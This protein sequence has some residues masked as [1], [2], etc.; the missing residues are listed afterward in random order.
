M[1]KA[2][3]FGPES[4]LSPS[5][6]RKVTCEVW[7]GLLLSPKTGQTDA[8]TMLGLPARVHG[9]P[10]G[11]SSSSAPCC[12]DSILGLPVAAHITPHN[13]HPYAQT[14]LWPDFPVCGHGTAPTAPHCASSCQSHA[15][16]LHWNFEAFSKKLRK[17]LLCRHDGHRPSVSSS[18][19]T[20]CP[21]PGTGDAGPRKL[22]K[23]GV[24]SRALSA[25]LRGADLLFEAG[26]CF[27][28]QLWVV[29]GGL[30]RLQANTLGELCW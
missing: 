28:T 19:I 16:V 21:P 9:V 24:G 14:S 10:P 17:L 8:P 30:S 5:E 20:N 25:G 11:V 6:S 4:H 18:I 23:C 1:A 3:R 22:L 15:P 27:S 29:F 13:V 26:L 2:L 12:A 7:T